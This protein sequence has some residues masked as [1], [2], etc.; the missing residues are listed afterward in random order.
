MKEAYRQRKEENKD[1]FQI[2]QNG[3]AAQTA[4]NAEFKTC[5]NNEV[6]FQSHK[7]IK[8]KRLRSHIVIVLCD[9]DFKHRCLNQQ[10]E[11]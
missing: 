5:Q 1:Y 9:F 7:L 10:R 4:M 2:I 3:K 6:F 8:A 11:I